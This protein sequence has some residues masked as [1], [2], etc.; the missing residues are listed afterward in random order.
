MSPRMTVCTRCSHHVMVS[1]VACPQCGGSMAPGGGKV[2]KTAAAVVLG[3]TM[4][5]ACNT[6][7]AMYGVPDTGDTAEIG[8]T[9][10]TGDTGEASEQ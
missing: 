4:G 2:L 10:D 9:G 1:S 6:G 7:E 8:D 3:L 5:T